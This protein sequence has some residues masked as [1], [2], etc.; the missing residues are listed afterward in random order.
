[1]DS[2]EELLNQS[3]MIFS[4]LP[5]L[6]ADHVVD[7]YL[8]SILGLLSYRLSDCDEDCSDAV[9]WPTKFF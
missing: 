9:A 3:G 6:N 8:L 7:R 4:I 1:M 2:D 5:P